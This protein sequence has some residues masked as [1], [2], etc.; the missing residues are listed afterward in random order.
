MKK[1]I[2]IL[3]LLFVSAGA[4]AQKDA[5]AKKIL[6]KASAAFAKAGGVEIGFSVKGGQNMSGTLKVKGNKLVLSSGTT[7]TWYDGK[8]QWTYMKDTEEV[9]ISNPSP[10]QL[11]QINPQVWLN[12][13]KKGFNYKYNGL[14]GKTYKVTLTPEASNQGVKSITLIVNSDT[15]APSQVIM[16]TPS[17]Q[18]STIVVSSY[19]TGQNYN[20]STFRFNPLLYPNA[21]VIDLR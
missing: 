14:S 17:G 10:K 9:N 1:L 4:W 13:Y 18:S 21:E 11:Q 2:F 6:D 7:T 3:S 19:R 12:S 8:T 16:T 15:Y 20:E 5:E